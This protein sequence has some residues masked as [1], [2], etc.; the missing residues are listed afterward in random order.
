MGEESILNS[1]KSLIGIQEDDT[2]F[3]YDILITIN[4]ILSVLTQVGVGPEEGYE[5]TGSK[6]TWSDFMADD[7]KMSSVKSYVYMRVKMLFDPPLSS[8]VAESYNASIK[9]FEWRLNLEAETQ[10]EKSK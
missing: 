5:I 7:P 1:I 4:S 3:D 2:S 10:G 8:S 6:E 9:E